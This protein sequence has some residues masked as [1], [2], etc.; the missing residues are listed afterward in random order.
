MI[1][2]ME[3]DFIVKQIK[4]FEFMMKDDC[5]G[6]EGERELLRFDEEEQ[7]VIKEFFQLFEDEE[8]ENFKFYQYK[9]E[10]FELWFGE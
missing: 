4:V 2:L 5:N 9:M 3:L 8:F 6:E 7:I 1:R 10:I